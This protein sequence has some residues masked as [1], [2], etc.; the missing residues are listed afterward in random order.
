VW[1]W[2]NFGKPEINGEIWLLHD[3]HK[4][5]NTKRRISNAKVC[6]EEAPQGLMLTL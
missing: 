1:C 6:F 4:N 3:P 2:R 5:V